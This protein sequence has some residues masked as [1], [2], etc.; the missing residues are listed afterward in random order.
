MKINAKTLFIINRSTVISTILDLCKF[1]HGAKQYGKCYPRIPCELQDNV[2][3][4][5][6]LRGQ[7]C[8]NPRFDC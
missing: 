4:W 2:M 8:I 3:Y 1:A 7:N 6:T 5:R